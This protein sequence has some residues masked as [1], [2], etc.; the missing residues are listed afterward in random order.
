MLHQCFVDMPVSW[1]GLLTVSPCFQI[2]YKNHLH[3]FHSGQNQV[4][5]LQSGQSPKEINLAR[6]VADGQTVVRI[7]I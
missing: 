2:R 1:V 7:I 6:K 3:I 4:P 5:L